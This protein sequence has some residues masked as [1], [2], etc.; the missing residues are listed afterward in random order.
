M[1]TTR[2]PQPTEDESRERARRLG[3]WGLLTHWEEYEDSPWLKKVLLHEEEERGRRSLERR[4]RRAKIGRFKPMAD[5]DWSWPK[6]ID[7]EQVEELFRLEFLTEAG[8]VVLGGTNGLGKTMI[9]Q[10]LAH[11]AILRGH[12]VRFVNASALLN[13][14]A[15]QDTGSALTRTLA[16]YVKPQLLVIDEVGYLGSTARHADLLFQLISLRHE[17]RSTVITT[18]KPFSEW[19]RVFPSAGCIL[20]L[21]DR[22][23][24]RSEVVEIKGESY[25]LKEAQERKALRAKDRKGRSKR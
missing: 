1:T 11:L 10:N 20:S 17:E 2:Q 7:R 9:A 24:H 14:L 4:L 18:N 15:A 21:V 13:D 22:I 25:R 5:F 12:T 3:L 23:I 19:N 8:N 16:R 6:E